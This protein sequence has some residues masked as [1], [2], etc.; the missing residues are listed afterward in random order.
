V[1][2]I[3]GFWEI[4]GAHA[5]KEALVAGTQTSSQPHESFI[6]LVATQ[7]A[8]KTHSTPLRLSENFRRL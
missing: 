4:T 1:K 2:N 6:S 3:T 5:L 7:K 8:S